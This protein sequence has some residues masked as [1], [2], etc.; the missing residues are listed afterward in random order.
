MVS[1]LWT[2]PASGVSGTV[3]AALVVGVV[4]L[5]LLF[6][7]IWSNNVTVG[8][9]SRLEL[10]PAPGGGH[11]LLGRSTAALVMALVG[12]VRMSR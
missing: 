2:P 10:L 12:S 11:L 4:V 1:P 6:V 5:I 7:F 9:S 8:S 3:L